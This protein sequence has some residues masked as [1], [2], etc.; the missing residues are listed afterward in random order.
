[1]FFLGTIHT[2]FYRAYV[3]KLTESTGRAT[4]KWQQRKCALFIFTRTTVSYIV[5]NHFIKY[6]GKGASSGLSVIWELGTSPPV[7][8]K[9]EGTGRSCIRLLFS[10]HSGVND[11][12]ALLQSLSPEYKAPRGRPVVDGHRHQ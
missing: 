9:I 3:S 6:D 11:L 10:W 2:I 12:A 7:V 1:M 5:L 4:R 8:V